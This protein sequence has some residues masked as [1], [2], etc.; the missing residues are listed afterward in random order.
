MI[1]SSLLF[2]VLVVSTSFLLAGCD[3]SGDSSSEQGAVLEKGTEEGQE[4][5]GE[6]PAAPVAAEGDPSVDCR[7]GF[8]E[9]FTPGL[10]D[11]YGAGGQDR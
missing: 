11:G 8:R 10:H 4:E 1:R 3:D 5:G 9:E 2:S 6:G 7:E